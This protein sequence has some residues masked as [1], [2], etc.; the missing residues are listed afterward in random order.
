[1]HGNPGQDIP[2]NEW[3]FIVPLALGLWQGNS[4]RVY[5]DGHPNLERFQVAV[6]ALGV[7]FFALRNPPR[8]QRIHECE[9]RYAIVFYRHPSTIGQLINL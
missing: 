9:R 4:Y 5:P 2:I 6:G 3:C 1:M 8:I 7:L